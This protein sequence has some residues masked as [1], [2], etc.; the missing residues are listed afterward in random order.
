MLG[1]GVSYYGNLLPI[2]PRGSIYRDSSGNYQVP[3]DGG[4]TLPVGVSGIVGFTGDQK[5]LSIFHNTS[6]HLE[7]FDIEE[8]SDVPLVPNARKWFYESTSL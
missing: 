5:L 6:Q 1:G 4:N 2:T 7:Q 8:F 3:Q